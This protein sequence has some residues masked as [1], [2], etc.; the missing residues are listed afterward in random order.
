MTETREPR[1]LADWLRSA[2]D[3]A[4]AT[5]F[6]HR[7]D[8][9]LPVPPDITVLSARAAA[10]ASVLAAIDRLNRFELEVLELLTA[11]AEPIALES[12]AATAPDVPTDVFL[13]AVER[14]RALALVWGNDE[15]MHVLRSVRDLVTEPCGLGAPI[16]DAVSGLS[17]NRL[18]DLLHTLGLPPATDRHTAT[19]QL[20]HWAA[21][22][23]AVGAVLTSAPPE[24]RDL[25]ERLTW[26]PPTGTTETAARTPAVVWA[27]QRALLVATGE[28]TVVLPREIGI[29]LRN[30]VIVR[31][32]NATPPP[33]DVSTI[34]ASQ[35]AH[36]AATHGA[37][38]IRAVESLLDDWST[39]PPAGLRTGGL[40]VRDVRRAAERL[41]RAESDVVLMAEIAYAAGLLASSSTDLWLPT[42]AYDGW[43]A[44]LDGQRW[45]TLAT[46]WLQMSRVPGLSGTRDSSGRGLAAL[47]PDL[48]RALAPRFRAATLQQ[49]ATLPD[50]VAT[51]GAS[52]QA[53]LQWQAP[54]RGGRFRDDLVAWTIVEAELLGVIGA[55]AITPAGRRLLAGDVA[56]AADTF[57][58]VLPAPV[59]TIVIQADMTAVAPGRV[60]REL[61]RELALL[62][63]V[64]ST[65][66]ATVYRFSAASVRRALDAG[67][68]ATEIH[69]LLTHVSSTPVP[70][71]LTYLVDDIAR[72][73]GRI[74]IG[75]ASAYIRCD[76]DAALGELM[77]DR[78]A[79]VL[80]LRKL[81]PTVLVANADVE[82]VLTTLRELGYAPAAESTSGDVVIKRPDEMRA[83]PA[84]PPTPL[85][86]HTAPPAAVIEA[87]VRALRAGDRASTTP[88]RLITAEEP[89]SAVMPST[90]SAR[91]L[92]A[93][94]DA[95][96]AGRAMWIGYVNAQGS[97][98]QRVVEPMSVG[99]GYLR[100]YD[101]LRDE[102]RTF[103]VHRITGV[104]ELVEEEACSDD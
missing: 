75:V 81:A 57:A 101:H 37:A 40:R 72:R 93:L 87:A 26:G 95:A 49:L 36:T 7:P 69:E 39:E 11:L 29:A 35:S 20:R 41:D 84:R 99:G 62:A 68:S 52:V 94:Q 78:R 90:S 3:A 70:Q 91:T 44:S 73:H 55:G 64:E 48:D 25:L 96:H 98:S 33:L 104:A 30:G 58:A 85:S 2:D 10:Q 31:A 5:L 8:L 100:A 12:V 23:A 42:P 92:I 19:E 83:P 38:F 4:L 79:A 60:T 97:A 34:G 51:T 9:A 47:G 13:A 71:P 16:A 59:A 54:R 6:E 74:R 15:D 61:A 102:V 80:G 21:D 1:S 22:A 17:T 63:D 46:A 32:A 56:G 103:A 27:L 50:G 77:S 89:P 88:R 43:R 53:V 76:D 45:A 14:L 24:V 66:H 18:R 28:R 65:G 82:K 67:R 86:E